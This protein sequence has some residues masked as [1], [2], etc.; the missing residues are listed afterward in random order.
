MSAPIAMLERNHCPLCAAPAAEPV[1]ELAY[2][3]PQMQAF[4]QRFYGDRIDSAALA[5]EYF[6]IAVC[7]QCQFIYQTRILNGA[8][9]DALYSR[10]VD[11]LASLEKKRTYWL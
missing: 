1:F 5:N 2:S 8:G 9:M 10:W 11:Q 7:P 3:D 4:L 6:Q